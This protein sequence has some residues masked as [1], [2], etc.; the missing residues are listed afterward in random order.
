MKVQRKNKW[1]RKL[2]V[3]NIIKRYKDIKIFFI[4]IMFK[5]LNNLFKVVNTYKIQSIE[6]SPIFKILRKITL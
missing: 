3:K 4:Y 1:K 6:N 2:I 5:K